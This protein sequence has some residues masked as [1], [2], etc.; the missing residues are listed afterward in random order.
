MFR[1]QSKSKFKV[2]DKIKVQNKNKKH[3]NKNCNKYNLNH[4]QTAI[5]LNNQKLTYKSSKKW[6]NKITNVFK[7]FTKERCKLLGC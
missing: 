7:E 5:H 6:N 3:Q 1:K 2:K 4:L